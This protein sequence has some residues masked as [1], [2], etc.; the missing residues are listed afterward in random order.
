[1]FNSLNSNKFKQAYFLKKKRK[2]LNYFDFQNFNKMNYARF[3]SFFVKSSKLNN[4]IFN[5]N[6]NFDFIFFPTNFNNTLNNF[7][8]KDIFV[9]FSEN[10]ILSQDH[11]NILS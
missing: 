3:F 9:S 5:N 4:S 1:M 10:T 8:N 7:N 11:L 6:N 2:S